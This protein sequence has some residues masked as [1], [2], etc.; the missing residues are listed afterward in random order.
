MSNIPIDYWGGLFDGEGSIGIYMRKRVNHGNRCG[1]EYTPQAG[2]CQSSKGGFLIEKM[3]DRWGGFINTRDH[4]R[5]NK[6]DIWKDSVELNLRGPKCRAF[7][8]EMLPHLILKKRQAELVLEFF[9][10]QGENGQ[11]ALYPEVKLRQMAI[12]NELR[13]LNYRGKTKPELSDP[14]VASNGRVYYQFSK[15]DLERLYL[16]KKLSAR[17]IGEQYGVKTSAV[18]N[19]LNRFGIPMRDPHERGKLG[20]ERSPKIKPFA[21]AEE[22]EKAYVTEG[23]STREVGKQFGVTHVQVIKTLRRYGIPASHNKASSPDARL[24][25]KTA[26][27]F[28]SEASRGSFIKPRCIQIVN[29]S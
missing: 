26:D 5:E 16:E 17:E 28:L 4:I 10:L 23:K 22:L 2:I 24:K 7:L 1:V 21:T 27:L 19:T 13:L 6:N 12:Y 29:D 9:N 14:V 8:E 15:A 25:Q 20:S 11:D 18:I 3:K